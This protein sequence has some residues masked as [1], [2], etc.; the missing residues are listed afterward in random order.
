M[1]KQKKQNMLK[2]SFI[3]KI[4]ENPSPK[5]VQFAKYAINLKKSLKS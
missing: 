1:Q 3:A 4:K 5:I 2:W